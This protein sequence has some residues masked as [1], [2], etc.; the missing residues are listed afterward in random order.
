MTNQKLNKVVVTAPLNMETAALSKAAKAL[1]LPKEED[2]QMDLLYMTSIFVSTGTNK[3]G[4]VFLGSEL[5]K[6]RHTI[7]DKA[8]DIEHDEQSLIGQIT[9][10]AFLK[11]DGALLNSDKMHAKMEDD[12]M[13]DMDMD[14]AISSII[15][16]ARFP[17]I[18]EEIK[19]GEWAV[20][21]EAYF[22]TFDIK[23]GDFIIPREQAEEKGY[24][25]MV[26]HVV[27]LK[28]GKKELGFHLIGRVLRGITFA[29][30]GIVKSPANERSLILEAASV[31]EFIEENKDGAKVIDLSD[32]SEVVVEDVKE[33]EEASNN[34]ELAELVKAIIREEIGF[35]K[36]GN[37]EN[38]GIDINHQRPGTCVHFKKSIAVRPSGDNSGEPATDLS[39][40]PMYNPPGSGDNIPGSIIVAENYCSLFERE[41]SSRPGNAT[42]PECWRN[43]FARTVK[44]EVQSFEEIVKMKRLNEGLQSLQDVL[45]EA[46]KF[47]R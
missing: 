4:A 12:D 37:P 27:R 23:V 46:R 18:A 30:V 6:A 13:D 45:D 44:E 43:V 2:R 19:R 11:Q 35:L 33:K 10:F 20:S 26:G 47:L 8:V 31:N 42:L 17:D 40:L 1:N 28:R 32:F 21:M 24:D 14:I 7:K 15:H 38:A 34:T 39:Q 9:N 3:N 41:C 5:V 16:A 36:E 29:G 25:Q 22:E